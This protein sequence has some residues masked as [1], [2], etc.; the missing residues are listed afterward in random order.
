MLKDKGI[1]V[2]HVV[3]SVKFAKK[4]ELAGVDA[5]VAEGFEAGG[6][7]GRE[8]TTTLVLIPMVRDAISIPLMA[9]GGIATGRGMLAAEV[10]GADGVQIGSRFAV[11]LESSAHENF[12]KKVIELNEGETLLTLKQI[13]PVRLI[14][15]KFCLDVQQAELRGASKDELYELLGKRRAKKGIF[16]GEL[17][18]GELEIGQVSAS[19]QTI[20]P[21]SLILNEIWDEYNA[22]KKALCSSTSFT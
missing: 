16:E 3:S 11:S 13:T 19:I 9:A 21:A 6:H 15:N 7:N 2:V 1:T 12:K 14:K 8:E 17:N 20:Q 4:A 10:L 22:L 18:E 5:V